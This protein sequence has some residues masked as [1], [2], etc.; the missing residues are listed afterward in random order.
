[1]IGAGVASFQMAGPGLAGFGLLVLFPFLMAYAAS[2]DL[3]TMLIPNWVSLAL[4]AG[5]VP[6]ALAAGFDASEFGTH[7]G[8][9]LLVL[10]AT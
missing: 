5:F 8:A 7:I 3:L 6:M 1:M 2:R 9:G 4:V 10:S